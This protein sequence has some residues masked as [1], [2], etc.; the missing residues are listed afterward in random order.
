MRISS[1]S[2]DTQNFTS[3]ERNNN[4]IYK[5]LVTLV[6]LAGLGRISRIDTMIH[7]GPISFAAL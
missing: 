1:L 6:G 4:L 7:K 3:L 2:V 5:S